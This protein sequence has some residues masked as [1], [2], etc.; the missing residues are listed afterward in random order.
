MWAAFLRALNLGKHSCVS[1]ATLRHLFAQ[2]GAPGALTHR[3]SGNVVFRSADPVPV[4]TRV[5]EALAALGIRTTVILRRRD[6]L[7]ASLAANPFSAAS[8][9]PAAI[10]VV[11]L[12]ASPDP[13][14][15]SRLSVPPGETAALAVCGR[16]VFLHAPPGYSGT[17]LTGAWLERR[18]GVAATV[19]KRSV[20]GEVLDLMDACAGRPDG[21]A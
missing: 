6:E 10:H 13:P 5:E 16:E 19:R 7:A 4:A 2:A 11:F 20:T 14:A 17:K 1:M 3:Q 21:P 15:L 18:L 12:A 8:A 9:D